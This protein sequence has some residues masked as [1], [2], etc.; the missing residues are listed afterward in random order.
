[1][2]T[3][4]LNVYEI[5]KTNFGEKEAKEV[6]GYFD[7]KAEEKYEHKKDILL[8]KEDKIELMSKIESTKIDMIKWFAA[9]FVSIALM[10]IGLYLKS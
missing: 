1:M 9:F 10:I 5:F 8:T 7:A 2:S 4:E 6:L 3:T